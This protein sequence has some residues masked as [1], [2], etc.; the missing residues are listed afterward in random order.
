MQHPDDGNKFFFIHRIIT[1]PSSSQTDRIIVV[2]FSF[3]WFSFFLN[4]VAEIFSDH[5]V[6][7]VTFNDAFLIHAD[8]ILT[9]L[10]IYSYL[11]DQTFH[12]SATFA[13]S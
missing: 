10:S 4:F 13:D 2:V 12:E 8:E 5:R 9:A 7:R 1:D 3:C 6:A 11:I